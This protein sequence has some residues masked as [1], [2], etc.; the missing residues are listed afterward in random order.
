MS[1][2]QN[3]P[4]LSVQNLCVTYPSIGERRET[5]AVDNISFQ[6]AA[7]EKLGFVGE[8]GSG[9]STIGRA[10]VRL[11]SPQAIVS[12]TALFGGKPIFE[13]DN[14]ALRKFRGE[15]VSMITF[16]LGIIQ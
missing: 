16:L 11:I 10:L 5:K 1:S 14:D 2:T 12:G 13:L 6:L 15:A 4:L 3:S 9:K 8:S 7:G